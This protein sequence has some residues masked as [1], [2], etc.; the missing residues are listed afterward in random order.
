MGSRIRKILKIKHSAKYLQS[1]F[2]CPGLSAKI[3]VSECLE[4]RKRPTLQEYGTGRVRRAKGKSKE[5]KLKPIP[6]EHCR[7]CLRVDYNLVSCVTMHNLHL[8][9]ICE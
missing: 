2:V 9:T 3:R 4:R 8:L 6:C 5:L 7:Y 1:Y